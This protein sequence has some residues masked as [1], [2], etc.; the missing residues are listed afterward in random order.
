MNSFTKRG[1]ALIMA[2]MMLFTSFGT[3]SFAVSEKQA[4]S[5]N[6]TATAEGE[7]MPQ[8]KA[9]IISIIDFVSMVYHRIET[10]DYYSDEMDK[11]GVFGYL[12]EPKG[13]YFY[14]S[15]DPWQRNVGYNS[16][17]DVVAPATLINFE[18]KRLR[19]EYGNKDWMIQLWKGQYGLLFYGAEVGVYTKPKDREL[20]HYD[21]ASDEEMLKMEMTFNYKR[22]GEWVKRF[23]RPYDEYWWCTGF[24]A[25]NKQGDFSGIKIDMR[26]TAKNSTMLAKIKSA[27]SAN[28]ISY[29]SKGLDV[30]FSY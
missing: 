11:S 16:I 29:A 30:Y 20:M 25:G 13:M 24:L 4:A 14:T 10:E 19:F 18:T 8:W 21:A 12:Y 26:I 15:A 17:F 9:V 3:V 6:V 5:A 2:L 27:L 28:K 1:L 7:E 22:N 23:T